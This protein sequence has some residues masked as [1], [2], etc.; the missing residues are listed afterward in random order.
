MTRRRG[1]RRWERRLRVILLVG[2]MAAGW[3]PADVDATIFEDG[4][5]RISGCFSGEGCDPRAG[6]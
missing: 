5:F 2:T 4:S 6:E 1:R 3:A